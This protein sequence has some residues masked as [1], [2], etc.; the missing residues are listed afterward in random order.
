MLI[1]PS[2]AKCAT[3]RGGVTI[4]R[5]QVCVLKLTVDLHVRIAEAELSTPH[6][7]DVDYLGRLG[8]YLGGLSDCV[9][10]DFTALLIRRATGQDPPRVTRTPLMYNFPD[11]LS[12]YRAL[13]D[14]DLAQ[15][16]R[17]MMSEYLFWTLLVD[18][19]YGSFW[20]R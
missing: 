11:D 14:S 8:A 20:F 19:F 17:N 7:G 5:R 4:H 13:L 6:F 10:D 9:W 3:S 16:L 1:G 2:S 18:H 15:T 12:L